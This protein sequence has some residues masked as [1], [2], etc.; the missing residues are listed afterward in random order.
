VE[1]ERGK[2]ALS[3]RAFV[4]KLATGAAGAAVALA[5]GVKGAEALSTPQWSKGAE[6]LGGTRQW[7]TGHGAEGEGKP[8]FIPPAAEM[9]PEATQQ[10][11]AAENAAPAST[12]L[13]P[14]APPPWELLK[15]LGKGSKVVYGWRVSDLSPVMDGSFVLTLENKRGRTHRVHVC[16]NEGRPAGLVYTKQ[17]DLVVMNGGRGDLPTEEGLAQAVAEV[18]H[19]LAANEAKWQAA[20]MMTALLSQAKRV[21]MF[22]AAAKLR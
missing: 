7:P 21:E 2:S 20:P 18:A 12:V 22:G 11:A 14:D 9:Q 3:R 17:L 16:R 4:G 10:V 1:K 19:V 6:A 5:A 15:P 8:A 13:P